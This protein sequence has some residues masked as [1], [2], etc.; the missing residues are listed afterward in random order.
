MGTTKASQ[1]TLMGL[2]FI[3]QTIGESIGRTGGPNKRQGSWFGPI[4]NVIS[5]T[6]RFLVNCVE[7]ILWAQGVRT[8]DSPS[9]SGKERETQEQELIEAWSRIAKDVV[10]ASIQSSTEVQIQLDSNETKPYRLDYGQEANVARKR[11]DWKKDR[12][13]CRSTRNSGMA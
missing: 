3:N 13:H 4:P 8:L 1:M 6:Y 12:F 11:G 9:S 7:H 10:E 2:S 5:L